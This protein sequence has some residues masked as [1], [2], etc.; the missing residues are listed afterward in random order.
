MARSVNV[1]DFLAVLMLFSMATTYMLLFDGG[2]SLEISDGLSMSMPTR[3]LSTSDIVARASPQYDGDNDNNA[4]GMDTIPVKENYEQFHE[5]A[6]VCRPLEDHEV[7][8]G[9]AIALSE[10]DISMVSHHC[11]RWGIS[12]PISIAVWTRLSPEEVMTKLQSFPYNECQP[13]QMAIATLSPASHG[14][15]P[16]AAAASTS[17][18]DKNTYPLNQMRNLAIMGIQT[19]HAVY[20]DVE[21]WT[22]VDLYDTLHT[23]SVVNELA[24]NPKLAI[25]LPSFEVDTEHC[26]SRKK[27]LRNVPTSFESLVVQLSEKSVGIMDP[28][29]IALQGSTLYRSWVKQEQGELVDIDCVSSEYYEPFLAVRYCEGLPPFQEVLR[30]D[31]NDDDNNNNDVMTEDE[32]EDAKHDLM[33]TWIIHLLRLG[34]NLKQVGGGFVVNLPASIEP[35]RDDDADATTNNNNTEKNNAGSKAAVRHLRKTKK[36]KRKFTRHEFLEWLDQTVPD[37]R[38]VQ[39]CDYFET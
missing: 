16:G 2:E 14:H 21:M 9:L 8:F 26:S 5:N 25:V 37:Q 39:R 34:F 19:T 13:Q 11:K 36:R 1:V 10:K 28:R 15:Y 17:T 4:N 27:C 30:H 33:S 6:P 3:K 29:D 38:S 35:K 31:E 32:K 22:S 20:L 23:P 24:K 12:A 18:S 7:T